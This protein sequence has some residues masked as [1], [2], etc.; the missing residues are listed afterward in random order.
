MDKKLLKLNI[1]LGHSRVL[2]APKGD[3]DG[4]ILVIDTVSQSRLNII[5]K[6]HKILRKF[7]KICS[8][9][10]RLTPETKL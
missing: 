1:S 7:Q 3:P 6:N 8:R 5:K 2:C 10:L 4:E 9:D